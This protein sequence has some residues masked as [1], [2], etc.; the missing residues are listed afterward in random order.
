MAKKRPQAEPAA[1][2]AQE[3]V[4]QP[5]QQP[6]VGPSGPAVC[7]WSV[8]LPGAAALAVEATDAAAAIAIHDQVN[9]VIG[10]TH[11]HI[12]TPLE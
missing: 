5:A 11:A 3:Q 10:T 4:Q 6:A 1:Q 12:V 2:P 9:G 8:Q 7:R